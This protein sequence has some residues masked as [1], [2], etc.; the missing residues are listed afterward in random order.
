MDSLK[1]QRNIFEK[2]E[3]LILSTKDITANMEKRGGG[4]LDLTLRDMTDQDPGYY[5]LYATF[6]TCD[7]MGANFINSTLERLASEWSEMVKGVE[8]VMSILSNY[9]PNCLVRAE[10][11]CPVADLTDLG[12]H[13]GPVEF[14]RK[15]KRAVKIANIDPHRATTHNKGILNGVD[16]VV[17]ATGNDF[18]AVEACGHTY[19]AKDGHY[20]SLT[21]CE[22]EGEVFRFWIDLP[23]AIGTVGGLTSLH[24][25]PNS[26]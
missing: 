18:R 25:S 8:V 23:L 17:L 4:L 5:Q 15:F 26:P 11:S 10:V 7:A 16:A 3:E 9:T 21:Y 19:A 2:K 20:R 6:K 12:A 22:V 13:I 1:S 24:P 14:A